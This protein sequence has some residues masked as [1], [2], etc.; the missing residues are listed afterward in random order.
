MDLDSSINK[1]FKTATGNFSKIVDVDNHKFLIYN[2]TLT[3]S[4]YLKNLGYT[5]KM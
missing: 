2:N 3:A 1:D 4:K 5:D